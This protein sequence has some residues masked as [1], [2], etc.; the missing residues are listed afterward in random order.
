LLATTLRLEA[1]FSPAIAAYWQRMQ[2]RDGFK[3]AK[4]A[5]QSAAEAQN[6]AAKWG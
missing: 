4:A 5:Q 6:V 1:R 2:D 3:R